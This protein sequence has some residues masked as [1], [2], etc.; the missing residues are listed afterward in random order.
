MG[1]D[2]YPTTEFAN[3]Q[4]ARNNEEMWVR[5]I[6]FWLAFIILLVLVWVFVAGF[7]GIFGLTN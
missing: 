3:R 7:V 2:D 4:P 1:P 5:E 6:G